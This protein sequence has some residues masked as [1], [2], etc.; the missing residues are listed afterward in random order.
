MCLRLY[1][2]VCLC[3]GQP[4]SVYTVF[5]SLGTELVLGLF[6]NVGAEEQPELFQE[7]SQLCT[8]HWHGLIS[9]PVNVKVPMWSSGFSIALDARNK[10]MDII[11]DKLENDKEGKKPV[12]KQQKTL[13]TCAGCCWRCGGYGLLSLVD[14]E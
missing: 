4:E 3:S 10:L 11:K 1:T 6:L 2:C 14:A 12:I 9:A 5:K 8:Q 13:I 7:I